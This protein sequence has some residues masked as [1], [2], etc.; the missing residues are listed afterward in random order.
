[1]FSRGIAVTGRQPLV[2]PKT[3]SMAAPR[4]CSAK[5]VNVTTTQHPQ[6]SWR[7]FS[8]LARNGNKGGTGWFAPLLREWIEGGKGG[9]G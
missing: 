5:M 2:R 4:G 1:M 7:P 6:S 9:T 3:H 8:E